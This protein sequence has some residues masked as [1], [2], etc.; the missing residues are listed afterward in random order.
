MKRLHHALSAGLLAAAATSVTTYAA[1]EP[2]RYDLDSGTLTI[3]VVVAGS[4]TYGQVT[5]KNRGDFVFDVQGATELPPGVPSGAIFDPATGVLTLPAVQVGSDTYLDVQLRDIG[6]LVFTLQA[7]TPL[8]QSTRDEIDTLMRANEQLF[9]T[10]VPASGAA[11]LALGDACHLHNGRTLAYDIAQIDA[12]IPAYRARE[13]YQ[14]G[15]KVTNL[16]VLA[17]RSRVNG[18]GSTRREIDVEYDLEFTDGTAARSAA[19]TLISGSSAGSCATPQTG[20]ALRF[21]GNR[22]LVETS[23]QARNIRDQRYSRSTGAALS[24]SVYHR[25]AIE[26]RVVDPMGRAK[27][28]VITGPGPSGNAGGSAVQFSLKMI[29]PWL[30]RDAPELAGKNNNYLNWP[31][32][33]AFRMCRIAGSNVPVAAVADCVGM[34]GGGFD[35]GWGPTSTPNAAADQGFADQGWVAGGLYRFD[36]YDDDGWKTVNGQA[37]RTP[38]ASYWSKL[39]KLPYTFVQMTTGAS[40]G[41]LLPALNFGAMTTEQ[42][43]A[44]AASATP[45]T[46]AVS[47]AALPALPDGSRFGLLQGYE[48][49]EGSKTGNANGAY[50]PAYRTLTR[51]YPG[52]TATSQPAWP[53]SPKVADQASKSYVDYTL[54]YV[55]FNGARLISTASFR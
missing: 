33:D 15:R 18:D 3:P 25:R 21:Y 32:D 14:I 26:F 2:I 49:H 20:A 54:F 35:W 23:V 31:D 12:D 19:A 22:Q 51:N 27:Y 36:I 48:Y 40:G 17:Q 44:N 29:S 46:L 47:W 10:A 50:F 42:V 7:A 53:T 38:I 4:V 37:G 6:G 28:A 52:S 1:A 39:D 45:A 11:R 41:E 30:L 24:P 55:D 16:V 9:A 8:P 5:L 13:A 34:G 43:A